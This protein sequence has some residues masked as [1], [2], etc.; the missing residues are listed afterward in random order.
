MHSKGFLIPLSTL[1]SASTLFADPLYQDG[2]NDMSI[3]WDVLA[4]LQRVVVDFGLA[5]LTDIPLGSLIGRLPFFA[6]MFSPLITLLHPISPLAWLPIS[7]LLFQKVEPASSWTIFICPIW[8]MVVNTAEGVR[9]ISQDYLNVARVLQ[10]SEWTVMCKILF[11][12]VLPAAFTGVRL[13]IDT[14]W[15]V[16]VAVEMFIG[17]LGIGL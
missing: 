6:C 10:L 1:G 4:S 5:A 7:L 17:G 14:A 3:G 11:P 8:P 12:V 15:L 9:R 13:S 2:P 16:I